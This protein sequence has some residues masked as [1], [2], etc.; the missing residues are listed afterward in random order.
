MTDEQKMQLY[1][2]DHE[3]IE[4]Y[5][6]TLIALHAAMGTSED[7]EQACG[8]Q[9]WNVFCWIKELVSQIPKLNWLWRQAATKSGE[10]IK[11]VK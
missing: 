10:L 11:A 9:A 6:T 5:K 1:R 7:M 4:V 3:A 2:R 8:G